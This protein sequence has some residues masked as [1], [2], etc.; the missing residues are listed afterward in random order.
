MGFF[1]QYDLETSHS[2]PRTSPTITESASED[3]QDIYNERGVSDIGMQNDNQ[4]QLAVASNG[5]VSPK[6]TN[7][8]T[9]FLTIISVTGPSTSLLGLFESCCEWHSSLSML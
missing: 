9:K 2:I 4:D 6:Y 5:N 8:L 3:Q 1:F 7:Q